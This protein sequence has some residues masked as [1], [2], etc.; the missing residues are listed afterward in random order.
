M[1]IGDDE[2]GWGVDGIFNFEGGCYAKVIKLSAEKE[3]QIYSCTRRFGTLMENVAIDRISRR[4][5]LDDDSFTENTRAA[6][7]IGYIPNAVENGR[8]GHPS[9]VVLLT[10]DAFGVMPPVAKLTHEQAMF[11]FMSGYTARVAGTEKGL[12][13]PASTFS[14]CFGAPFLPR[15]P[16]V[17][18]KMLGEKLAQHGSECW[19]VNTGWSGG[20]YGVGERMDINH[21]RAIID[22][23]LAGRL[24]KVATRT[25]PNLNLEV[26]VTCEGVPDEVLDPRATWSDKKQFDLTAVKLKEDFQANM[27]KFDDD[28]AREI[29]AH[30]PK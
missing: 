20:P 26:P 11:H 14:A 22:E 8:G 24:S 13:E 25:D 2:H 28:F 27:A 17:Y 15:H 4:V 30:G 10:C 29:A 18:A 7:P 21:T 6:Y 5:D 9:H 3:P 1:L 23:I 19:L 16:S 12:T